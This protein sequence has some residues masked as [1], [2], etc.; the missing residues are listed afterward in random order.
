MS[1]S[2]VGVIVGLGAAVVAGAAALWV[3]GA[4]LL[5]IGGLAGWLLHWGW[6]QA[7]RRRR[8][9]F[10]IEE[11]LSEEFRAQLER[12]A[13][14]RRASE[15]YCGITVSCYPWVDEEHDERDAIEASGGGDRNDA[16]VE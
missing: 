9:L 14:A 5:V 12:A 4:A 7:S 10:S 13:S 8:S 6:Q 15:T 1:R 2:R 11:R 16:I 3:S